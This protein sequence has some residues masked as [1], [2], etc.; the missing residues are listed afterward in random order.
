ME[1]RW[2]TDPAF[3]PLWGRWRK[4]PE[5][6]SAVAAQLAP[7]LNNR[8]L[9]R[10]TDAYNLNGNIAPALPVRQLNGAGSLRRRRPA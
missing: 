2:G 3:L 6:A 1:P 5:G 8:S 9:N 4:A 10:G 7:T